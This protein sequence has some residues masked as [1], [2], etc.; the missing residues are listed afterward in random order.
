MSIDPAS[1]DRLC[2]VI[3]Q[4]NQQMQLMATRI[5]VLERELA[6]SRSKQTDFP[7]DD[8][9]KI[10]MPEKFDGKRNHY[11]AFITQVE[12]LF[13]LHPTLFSRDSQKVAAVG[14]LLKDEAAEWFAPFVRRRDEHAHIWSDFGAFKKALDM[15][16]DDPNRARMAEIR[17][18]SLKQDMR[19]AAAYTAEFRQLTS[20]LDYNDSGSLK[21]IF[22]QGLNDAV[23]DAIA[24]CPSEPQTLDEYYQLAITLDTRATER[25]LEKLRPHHTPLLPRA[26][27]LVPTDA[28]DLDATRRGPLSDS[29]RQRRVALKLCMYCGSDTHELAN[30]RS[31]PR[32][33]PKPENGERQ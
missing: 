21:A 25:R 24:M 33:T 32:R 30:C 23:K 28:M 20:E 31:K 2:T 12:L 15:M 5:D 8:S 6:D 19:S 11:A 7:V 16:Y 9:S 1:F 3:D 4:N 29:E 14:R 17:L 18:M 13:S 10:V 26:P 22:R 27:A